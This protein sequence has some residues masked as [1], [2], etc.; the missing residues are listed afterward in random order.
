MENREKT[1][2]GEAEIDLINQLYIGNKIEKKK[3]TTL[4][5][6]NSF[7]IQYFYTTNMV[8]ILEI[9]YHFCF[10]IIRRGILPFL[11]FFIIRRGILPFLFFYHTKR[12]ST[13]SVF[14][15]YEEVFYHFC[16]FIIRRGILP[17]LFFYH[18]K[19]Y[20]TISVFLSYEE[21]F[22]HFCFSLSYEEVFYHFCFFYHTKRYSTIS[23]FFS[24]KYSSHEMICVVI[25]YFVYVVVILRCIYSMSLS[26]GLAILRCIYS[27]SLSLGLKTNTISLSNHMQIYV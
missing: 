13:I 15:S 8:N 16:F 25:L 17:F 10:F 11:G 12:Y 3:N 27:M 14:L 2:G 9:F 7:K 26:L 22:Y 24:L 18:T 23:V 20:S 4:S 6:R 21:V 5:D 1:N 19:R